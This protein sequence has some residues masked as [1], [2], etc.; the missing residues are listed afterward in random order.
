MEY[1]T[2]TYLWGRRALDDLLQY[3]EN[4]LYICTDALNSVVAHIDNSAA[5]MQRIA[6][7]P[8]GTPNE[9]APNFTPPTTFEG[10]EFR[11]AGYRH[12]Q[13]AWFYQV[14]RR[15]L[16]STLGTW[17]SRDPATYFD[18]LNI[19]A[20]VSDSPVTYR[21]SAGLAGSAVTCPDG[22]TLPHTIDDSCKC[23]GEQ[24][25]DVVSL[26]NTLLC[27]SAWNAR[28]IADMIADLTLPAGQPPV[29][30]TAAE[31]ARVKACA[32]HW[33]GMGAPIT[34]PRIFDKLFHK[35]DDIYKCMKKT[36]HKI[37]CSNC[38]GGAKVST[39]VYRNPIMYLCD[40]W[41]NNPLGSYR[42]DKIFHEFT[43]S[44]GGTKDYGYVFTPGTIGG[45]GPT[46][47]VPCPWYDVFCDPEVG[48]PATLSQALLLEN[49]ATY[50]NFFRCITTPSDPS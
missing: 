9:L 1:D 24:K 33:F 48:H 32:D 41:Y 39:A 19:Y 14:R 22:S 3:I 11:F 46:Y 34:D 42:L 8:Y 20:Y 27:K 31:I 43:H 50:E 40:D 45:T 6:Y 25:K 23:W 18:G 36:P 16:S 12:D 49:A 15:C 35:F 37:V 5:V 4:Q 2:R 28:S 10:G 13:H 44:C 29:S 17:M 21:D 47:S 26:L 7:Q 30:G 38:S